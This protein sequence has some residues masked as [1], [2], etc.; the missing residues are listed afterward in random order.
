MAPLT[1]GMTHEAAAEHLRVEVVGT[2]TREITPLLQ[3][4]PPGFFG[5]VRMLMCEVDY[6]A[7]LYCGFKG[8][9]RRKISTPGKSDRF[10]DEVI[11]QASGDSNYKRF[12]KHLYEMYRVGLVHLRAPKIVTRSDASTPVLTWTLMTRR[13]RK[14]AYF[15]HFVLLDHLVPYQINADITT[16]PL[17]IDAFF[18]DFVAACEFF[19]VALEHERD[20][21]GEELLTRW[22]QTADALSEAE[23]TNLRW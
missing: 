5:A 18:D 16:L 10:I 11:S 22:R 14:V 4:E 12:A 7:A 6:V 17:S 3:L 13:N 9:D 1:Q 19:A 21:G 2:A 23:P 8:N 20:V 15:G